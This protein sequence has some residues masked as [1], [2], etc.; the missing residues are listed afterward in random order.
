MFETYCFR[1][2]LLQTNGR[3]RTSEKT[4]LQSILMLLCGGSSSSVDL[5]DPCQVNGR[6]FSV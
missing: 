6:G 1:S 2:M 4:V 3:C 5:Q